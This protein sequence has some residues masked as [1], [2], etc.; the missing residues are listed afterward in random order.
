MSEPETARDRAQ[1]VN[2]ITTAL[3]QAGLQVGDVEIAA[4]VETHQFVRRGLDALRNRL[5][6]T[7]EPAPIFDAT[8]SWRSAESGD[9]HASP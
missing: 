7:T 5:P 6:K 4:M 3:E 9:D 2:E 8:A 1:T